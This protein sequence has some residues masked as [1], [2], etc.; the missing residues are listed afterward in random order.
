M[1][2]IG[3]IPRKPK[4]QNALRE[5]GK[6]SALEMLRDGE[7]LLAKIAQYSGLDAAAVTE[8][9]QSFLI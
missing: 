1:T 6:T 4:V 8:L 7:P 2:K 5:W 3:M 9:P